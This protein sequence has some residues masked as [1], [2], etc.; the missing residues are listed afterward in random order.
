MILEGMN[1]PESMK[2][3]SKE[4]QLPQEMLNLFEQYAE[5]SEEL[6]L[7]GLNKD[8]SGMEEKKKKNNRAG[9]DGEPEKEYSWAE[10][11]R[12]FGDDDGSLGM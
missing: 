4:E 10:S 9:N 8:G 1:I 5:E 2:S 3:K 12:Q 11:H 6:D 7:S